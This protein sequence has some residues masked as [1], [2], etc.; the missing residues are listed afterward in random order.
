MSTDGSLDKQIP[1]GALFTVQQTSALDDF[2]EL[3]DLNSVF[4]E[5]SRGS[6]PFMKC[7]YSFAQFILTPQS[8]NVSL[9][10]TPHQIIIKAQNKN[11]YVF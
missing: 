9:W 4:A 8:L 1:E 6:N 7:L 11:M 2:P 3:P 10:I 5:V